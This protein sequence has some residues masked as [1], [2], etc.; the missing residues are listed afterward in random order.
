[1][2]Q[3]LKA[4]AR[5][6]A[7]TAIGRVSSHGLPLRDAIESAILSG[8]LAAVT[9]EPSEGINEQDTKNQDAANTPAE[10]PSNVAPFRK[11]ETQAARREN[12]IGVSQNTSLPQA[13]EL[14][15]DF[16]DTESMFNM[17][18]WL[19]K[20]LEAKGAKKTGAGCGMGECDI[21]IEIDGYKFNV[22]IKPILP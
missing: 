6:L 2:T 21:D 10:P 9:R 7:I 13:I 14:H 3:D 18:D 1:M 22:R 12:G 8:M 20:A 5:E 19:Q 4:L 15:P 17:R 11:A 16:G